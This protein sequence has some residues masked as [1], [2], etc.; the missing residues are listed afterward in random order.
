MIYI[1]VLSDSMNMFFVAPLK[2]KIVKENVFRSDDLIRFI[3]D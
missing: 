2:N 3:T 1:F